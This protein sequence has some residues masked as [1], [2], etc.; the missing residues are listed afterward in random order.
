MEICKRLQVEN[1]AELGDSVKVEA[2]NENSTIEQPRIRAERL[3]DPAWQTRIRAK[4]AH[5]PPLAR[6][7]RTDPGGTS[8]KNLSDGLVRPAQKLAKSVTETSS[9]VREPKTYDEAVNGLINRNRW[10]KAIDEELW[11]LDSPAI[12]RKDDVPGLR[13][14]ARHR[15]YC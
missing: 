13:D 14:E 10:Q 11:I 4:S 12:D 1:E 3:H 5:D 2:L 6:R 9:K 15:F 8:S 7:P